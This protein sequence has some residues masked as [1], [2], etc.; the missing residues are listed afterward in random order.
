MI[1]FVNSPDRSR[2]F[3]IIFPLKRELFKEIVPDTGAMKVGD[4]APPE[5]AP[6]IYIWRR[7][8]AQI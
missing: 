6:L 7:K 4:A 5:I 1:F 3:L 2:S 8:N